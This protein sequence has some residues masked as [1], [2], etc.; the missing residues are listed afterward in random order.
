M[1]VGD[2]SKN[3]I[4]EIAMHINGANKINWQ[5]GNWTQAL[6]P[7]LGQGGDCQNGGFVIQFM[8]LSDA[9]VICIQRRDTSCT[10]QYVSL[11]TYLFSCFMNR[12]ILL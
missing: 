4:T 3:L 1:R 10:S 2:P 7:C 5:W 12:S 8:F 11:D 6:V 9:V